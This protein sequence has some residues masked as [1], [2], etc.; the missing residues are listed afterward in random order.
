MMPGFV[1]TELVDT[2]NQPM[3]AD[4]YNFERFRFRHLLADVQRSIRRIGVAPGAVAPDFELRTTDGS[5][6]RLSD[7]RG[8]PVLLHFGSFS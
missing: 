1:T 8:R 3:G 7:L 2:I 4:A 6:V 5:M